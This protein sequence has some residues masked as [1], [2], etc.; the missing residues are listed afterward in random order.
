[1]TRNERESSPARPGHP[2]GRQEVLSLPPGAVDELIRTAGAVVIDVR[3]HAE[4]EHGRLPGGIVVP[5]RN[6][7][8]QGLALLHDRDRPVVC[9]DDG[10]PVV[11]GST[12]AD[13]AAE[14]LRRQGHRSAWSLSGGLPAWAAQGRPVERGVNV[15]SK[16][17]GE[18]VSHEDDVPTVTAEEFRAWQTERDDV[19]LVDVRPAVEH[20]RGCVPGAVNIPG[21]ELARYAGDLAASGRTVVT[22]CAGRTRGIIA[23]QTLRML[24]VR[25]VV[26]LEN[27]TRGWMLAGLEL[28]ESPAPRPVTASPGL[29][30]AMQERVPA[31]PSLAPGEVAEAS[32]DR[33][34]DVRG[35]DEYARAH[36]VG[37]D[38]APGTQLVQ[39][40]DEFCGVDGGRFA[41]MDSGADDPRARLTSYWLNRMGYDAVVVSGGLEAWSAAGLPC[42][43]GP[44]RLEDGRHLTLPELPTATDAGLPVLDVDSSTSY[45]R[46]HVPGSTW[47]S[48]DRLEADVADLASVGGSWRGAALVCRHPG[49]VQARLAA[50]ALQARGYDRIAV[51]PLAGARLVDDDPR[52]AREPDDIPPT[53]QQLGRQAALDYLNWELTLHG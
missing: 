2:S 23:T 20:R 46:A 14:G 35:A 39:R 3:A 30:E 21:I 28:E 1:M 16:R 37:A 38:L 40:A 4:A 7:E 36:A 41:V 6:V 44:G 48:R 15:R 9:V 10:V 18:Q 17:F 11:D 51:Y 32:R 29:A 26:T 49:A 13:L 12:R 33:L 47:V 53:P 45:R 31:V 24:G 27:G 42:E 5:R 25:D 43:S 22:H 34:F 8:L 52:W 50:A 19:L